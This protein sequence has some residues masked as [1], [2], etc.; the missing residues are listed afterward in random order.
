MSIRMLKTLIA[1]ADHGTFSAAANAVFVT[2]AA[3]SQ[4]MRALEE[5][6]QVAIFDR[7][8][9]TPELTPV[10]QA[11]LA[12][13]REVVRAYDDIV[14]AVL[15]DEG[16]KGEFGLGAVPTSLTGL[17]P[18]AAAMLKSR[19]RDL[20]IGLLPGLTTHLI[21]QVERN[22]LNAALVSKPAVV[23]R[24]LTWH[25]I[26]SE[27]L[28]LIASEQV[29]SDDAVEILKTQPFIRFTRDAVVGSMIENWL[30]THDIAVA[31]TMELV[32]LDA[33][34]GMVLANLGVSI[35]PDPCVKTLNALPLKRLPL[36]P[37]QP[38]RQLGLIH[39][40]DS[41]KRRVVEEVAAALRRAA[42]IGEL[43]PRTIAA[44]P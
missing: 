18:L 44:A 36:G 20:R 11:I 22:S 12:K 41:T 13:A 3:V 8:T 17:V 24:G 35:I 29:E 32:G 6:L 5:E 37:G 43:S 14:P 1:I 28:V 40:S 31:D 21:H 25:P 38:E 2:H 42:E 30:Q 7:S 15:G 16:L 4:Q 33:I 34:S 9:R 26:V 23:P 10:G 39:R 27:P 19:Y